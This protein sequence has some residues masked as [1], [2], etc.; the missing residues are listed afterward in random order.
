MHAFDEWSHYLR[1]AQ[2]Q[3]EVLTDHQNLTYFRKPQN[4]NR[5]QACWVLDL[6]E[7]NFIIKHRSG[8]SNSKADILSR[9][10]DHVTEE[11]D[12]ENIILLK[13]HLFIHRLDINIYTTDDY[14]NDIIKRLEK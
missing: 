5:R 13:D 14:Y 4:L 9:R 3:I 7:Y 1:G 6:Q 10:A 12:N 2:E 11:K 8:K